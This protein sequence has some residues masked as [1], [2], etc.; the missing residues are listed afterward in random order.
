MYLPNGTDIN[1]G[2]WHDVLC[3]QNKDGYAGGYPGAVTLEL[4]QAPGIYYMFHKS[5][6][7]VAGPP[8]DAYPDRLLYSIIKADAESK[9]VLEKNIELMA[10]DLALGEMGAV[11]HANGRDWWVFTAKRNSNT[12]YT[13]LFTAEGITDTLVQ[14]IGDLPPA[15]QEIRG[16][17]NFSNNGNTLARFF[18]YNDLML[19]NF[20]R[21]TGLFSNYRT[22]GVKYSTLPGIDG[23]LA[24]SPSDRYLYV[25]AKTEAYQFDLWAQNI[26]GSQTT[27]AVWDG[28]RDPVATVFY[29]SQLGPDC[30]I[31]SQCGDMR[32]YHVIHYP[33]RPGLACEFEQRGL[34]LPTPSGAS[35]PYF[36]NF[37]LGPIDSPGLPCTPTVSVG[38]APAAPTGS[39]RAY[40]NPAKDYVVL[41]GD[42]LH[43]TG[44]A[45]VCRIFNALGQEV[46]QT[47]V[48]VG[49]PEV[50]VNIGHLPTGVYW[51]A[52]DG[53]LP[54]RLVVER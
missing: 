29:R 52:V 11:K 35:I 31:Y 53:L 42:W 19:Y 3:D 27:V 1:P 2:F 4:P 50:A 39:L 51:V 40:P 26:S 38:P 34:V 22:V 13:F 9:E 46:Q 25:M 28:F 41:R 20:D 10:D 30:K 14:T 48:P 45:A 21:E 37:R 47:G 6:K 15:N 24:F 5:I 23:G 8:Q 7:Y 18:P 44:R 54:V 43:L 17:T 16:Q 12:F 32:Y 33:D 49:S 36:P